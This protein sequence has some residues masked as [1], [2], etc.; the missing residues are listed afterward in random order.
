MTKRQVL[1]AATLVALPMFVGVSPSVPEPAAARTDAVPSWQM[2]DQHAGPQWMWAWGM[3]GEE[4]L[5]FGL[6]SAIECSFF[7]PIGGI[8]CGVTG[9]L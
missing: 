1:A 5:A 8:A 6:A 4:A 3:E 9:A 7:G 2:T